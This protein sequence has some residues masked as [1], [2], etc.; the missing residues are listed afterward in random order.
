MSEPKR[1]YKCGRIAPESKSMERRLK[2]QTGGDGWR[3]AEM[4]TEKIA[5]FIAYE[6][7]TLDAFHATTDA[8]TVPADTDVT[9]T[10]VVGG[11]DPDVLCP[12]C[13]EVDGE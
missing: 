5:A 8:V 9:V 1:C 7:Q 6:Y 4:R 3:E 12:A 13:K 2:I 10:Y 11:T